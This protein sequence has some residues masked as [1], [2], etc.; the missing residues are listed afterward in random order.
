L[1]RLSQT[2]ELPNEA[3]LTRSEA[4][5]TQPSAVRTTRRLRTRKL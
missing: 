1:A 5:Q 3:F 2:E 4:Q